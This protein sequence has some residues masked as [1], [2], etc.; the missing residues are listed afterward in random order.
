MALPEASLGF[1]SQLPLVPSADFHTNI[2]DISIGMEEK[3]ENRGGSRDGRFRICKIPRGISH[4][5]SVVWLFRHRRRKYLHS[6]FT[7]RTLLGNFSIV[8]GVLYSRSSE[9]NIV[10]ALL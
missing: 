8:T 6:S 2:G 10:H 9:S 7:D 1:L 4:D 5:Q 3:G